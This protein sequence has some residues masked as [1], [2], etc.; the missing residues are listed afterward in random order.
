[1]EIGDILTLIKDLRFIIENQQK[2]IERLN[3]RIESLENIVLYDNN[4]DIDF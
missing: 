4:D 3:S 2:E 1:M